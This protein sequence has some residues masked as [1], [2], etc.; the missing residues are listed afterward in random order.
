MLLVQ[1]WEYIRLNTSIKRT[2]VQIWRHIDK[3]FSQKR[4]KLEC[5][6]FLLLKIYLHEQGKNFWVQWANFDPLMSL[7]NIRTNRGKQDTAIY[8][9]KIYLTVQSFVDWAFRKF[10][11]HLLLLWISFVDYKRTILDSRASIEPK[12]QSHSFLIAAKFGCS[13]SEWSPTQLSS[14]EAIVLIGDSLNEFKAPSCAL[15]PKVSGLGGICLKN[16]VSGVS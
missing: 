3:L 6:T 8:F 11:G 15:V 10:A 1:D 2:L 12:A 4:D 13:W 5:H 9:S 16:G 14:E 7:L